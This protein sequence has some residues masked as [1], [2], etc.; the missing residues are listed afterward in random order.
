[1]LFNLA[2]NNSYQWQSHIAE[3]SFGKKAVRPNPIITN[4]LQRC[5]FVEN[6]GTGINKIKELCL[7]SNVKEPDFVFNEFFT[8]IFNREQIYKG[9]NEGLNSLLKTIIKAP[10]LQNKE[11]SERL[12][13]RPIK[14]IERQIS[15]LVKHNKAE[16]KGSKKTGGHYAI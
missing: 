16:R 1:M 12:N 5:N 13:G 15:E 11:L 9:L 3:H 2:I 7:E 14:T 4:L 6:M 10:G 8:V